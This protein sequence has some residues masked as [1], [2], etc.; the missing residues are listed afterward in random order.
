MPFRYS[1]SPIRSQAAR[2]SAYLASSSMA[3]LRTMPATSCRA[4]RRCPDQ[5]D[6]SPSGRGELPSSLPIAVFASCSERCGRP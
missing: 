1:V 2:P 6:S 4:A 3:H 5:A